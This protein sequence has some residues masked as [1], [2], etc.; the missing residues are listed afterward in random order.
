VVIPDPE[1]ND[2][3]AEIEEKTTGEVQSFS[4]TQKISVYVR[5]KKNL[6]MSRSCCRAEQ[7]T[8]LMEEKVDGGPLPFAP[9]SDQPPSPICVG[10]SFNTNFR[11]GFGGKERADAAE[12]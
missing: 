8:I 2:E 11:E 9:I 3:K 4:A 1:V 7:A 10:I 12:T 6:V 5:G